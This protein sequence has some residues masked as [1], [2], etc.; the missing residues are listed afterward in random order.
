MALPGFGIVGEILPVFTRKPLFA[1][2]IAAAGMIGRGVAVLLRVATTPLP[3]WHQPGHAAAVSC[4]RRNSSRSD[5]IHLLGG[6]GH[7][8]IKAKIRY[9]VPMLFCMA[10]Y[11]NFLIGGIS[12]VFLSDV[13]VNVTCARRLLRTLD[14]HYTIRVASS[15]RSSPGLYFWLPKMTGRTMNKKLGLWHFWTMFVFFNLTFFPMFIHRLVG[16]TASCLHLREGPADPERLLLDRGFLSR[17]LLPHLRGEPDVVPVHRTAKVPGHPWDS[18]GL[19][20][21][22]ATPIPPYKTSSGFRSS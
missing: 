4:S 11:F 20:W 15:S 1:F 18:L 6:N 14:F 5:R 2:R 17:G 16:P 9:E 13:P 22:T 21:Q 10:V 19:E 3:E 7:D 12:G 8:V